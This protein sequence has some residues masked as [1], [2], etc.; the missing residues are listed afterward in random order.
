MSPWKV[1]SRTGGARASAPEMGV[2][3]SVVSAVLLI[4]LALLGVLLVA[5]LVLVAWVVF[6]PEPDETWENGLVL[7]RDTPGAR[8]VD[9]DVPGT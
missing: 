3:L 9:R 2:L 4:L 5:T 6:A 1:P 8:R 7:T